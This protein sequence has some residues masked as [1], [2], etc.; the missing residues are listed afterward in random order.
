MSIRE[1][2][3]MS[4][5]EDNYM[6]PSVYCTIGPFFPNQFS[7]GCNDLTRNNGK[8]AR[9]QH[10]VLSGRVLEE[11]AKPTVNTI[12]EIWQPDANGIFRHP[13]DP[14]SGQADPGFFGWGR[15]RTDANGRYEF[16]TVLPGGYE[17]EDS[18]R[19]PHLNIMVLAIGLTR[20]LVTTAFFP[21]QPGEP[22]DL[23][24]NSVTDP[25]ARSRLIASRDPNADAD[26][27]IGYRFDLILRGDGETPFFLD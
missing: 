5:R 24:F 21:E 8:I 12:L 7:D 1:D 23:V 2:G 13:L 25:G 17:W 4:V 16:R 3:Q 18:M 22:R 11:G 10:I 27:A 14:R 6:A 26:G 9:G 19:C 20:R 15:T